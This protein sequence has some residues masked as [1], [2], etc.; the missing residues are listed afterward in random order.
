MP[1]SPKSRWLAAAFL[2]VVTIA[3]GGHEPKWL[4]VTGSPT[5]AFPRDHG[6]HPEYRTEWWYVTGLV[7]GDQGHR[8]GFQITFFRQGLDPTEPT[9]GTSRLRARQVMAAHLAVADVAKRRFYHTERLRRIA[10]GLASASE[11]NLDVSVDNWHMQRDEGGVITVAARDPEEEIGLALEL[12]PQRELVRHGD[13][14]Y[15]RKGAEQGNASVYVSFTRLEVVG[16]LELSGQSRRVE[17]VAWFDHEWGSSQLGSDVVGWDWFSLRLDDGNDLMVYRLR[18]ADGNASPFSSGSL[19]RSSGGSEVLDRDAVEAEPIDW[20]Q[21][22]LNGVRYPVG[23][24]LRVP[25]E[26]I[27]LEVRSL[28]P[29][30]EVDGTTTT[31]VV[32]WE[33][34]VEATGSHFGEGYLEMTGYAGSMEGIF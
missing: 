11:A 31:G 7:T 8:Y 26:G 3:E 32:Y 10:G 28:V 23:W 9:P 18:E 21:S 2:L 5:L 1:R 34:P 24:Q 16:E 14:G 12:R 27:D 29:G 17:G 19:V 15:S 13:G 20:W 4:Q 33:G 6:S 30:C 25:A 22:P